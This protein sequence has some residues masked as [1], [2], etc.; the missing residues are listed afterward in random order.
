MA[1]AAMMAS[2]SHGGEIPV[3]GMLAASEELP[4]EFVAFCTDDPVRYPTAWN[5]D[6]FR[7][8]SAHPHPLLRQ[9]L[10]SRSPGI[11]PAEAPS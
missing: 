5:L 3:E 10:P 4:A 2:W 6:Y 9:E 8:R 7:G 11:S 1:L